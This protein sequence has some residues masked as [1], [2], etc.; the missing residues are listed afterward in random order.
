METHKFLI[1]RDVV[2]HESVFPFVE[3]TMDTTFP[4]W[5]EDIEH[6]D[7]QLEAVD[8]QP[9]SADRSAAQPSVLP[10][11]RSTRCH[12]A[13]SYLLDYACTS[14]GLTEEAMCFSTLTNLCIQSDIT[15]AA[16]T[17]MTAELVKEPKSFAE[18]S[19]HSGWRTAVDKEIQALIDNN[20]WDVVSLPPGKKPIDCKWGYKA[21][22]KADGSLERLKARLVV[23]DFTQ[24]TL[25]PSL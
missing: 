4:S 2:F 1:S 14:L 15:S 19:L 10:P 16:Q 5:S 9:I 11:R 7:S 20:T 13:P 21:K 3:K 23:K 17:M 22:C 12:G 18:A 6:V 25:K 24:T 8:T